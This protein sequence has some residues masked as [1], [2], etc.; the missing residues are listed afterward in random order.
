MKTASWFQ[1]LFK[2]LDGGAG[3]MAQWLNARVAPAEDWS[4][5]IALTL[6]NSQ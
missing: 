3:E 6:S 1:Q 2:N 5:I 4:S